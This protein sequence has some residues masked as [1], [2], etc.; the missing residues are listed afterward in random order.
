[1]ENREWTAEAT[2]TTGDRCQRRHFDGVEHAAVG[3]N[4][5]C[6]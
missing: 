4:Q 2:L 3:L 6:D 1:M 5:I